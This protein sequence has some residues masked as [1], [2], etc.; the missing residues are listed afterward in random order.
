MKRVLGYIK[1]I[2]VLVALA[3]FIVAV[4]RT[5]TYV[6]SIDGYSCKFDQNLSNTHKNEIFDF[7]NE[8]KEFKSSSLKLLACK[9]KEKFE[10]I[11]SVQAFQFASGILE[12]KLKSFDPIFIINNDLVM[13]DNGNIFESDLFCQDLLASC[14]HV[15]MKHKDVV[16]LKQGVSQLCKKMMFGLPKRCFQ[17]Y[18]VVVESETESF[19]HDKSQENFSIQ[20]NAMNFPDE[21]ILSECEVL[22]KQLEDRGEFRR[23]KGKRW[24]ADVRF[25]NQ[26]VLCKKVRG[27]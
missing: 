8:N 1:I 19:M 7:I 11:K 3:M 12:V 23:R 14:C 27:R 4:T 18:D 13:T 10:L 15:R 22:K 25:K 17:D 20:F 6:F 26:L 24:I 21:K 2:A 5:A 16:Q 9:I